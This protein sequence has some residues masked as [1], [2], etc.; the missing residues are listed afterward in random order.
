[1]TI[2]DN[3]EYAVGVGWNAVEEDMVLI[4]DLVGQPPVSQPVDEHPIAEMTLDAQERSQGTISHAFDFL[5]FIP[6]LK[7]KVIEDTFHSGGTVENAPVTLRARI[8]HRGIYQR[9]NCYSIL[10]KAG[11][12]FTILDFMVEGELVATLRW[13]FNKLEA[14]SEP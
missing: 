14:I 1:M 2:S 9:Y 10:P 8:H 3:T 5:D 12:D 7:I 4:A 13:R 6:A 11:R